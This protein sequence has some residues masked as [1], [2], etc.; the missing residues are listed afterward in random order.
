MDSGQPAEAA[1]I[2]PQC[3]PGT[4]IV[5]RNA[6]VS[7]NLAFDSTNV[8]WGSDDTIMTVPKCGGTPRMVSTGTGTVGG[9]AVEGSNVYWTTLAN[10]PANTL[11]SAPLLGG[12]PT[13][14]AVF[15]GGS[16]PGPLFVESG[17][18]YVINGG[19]GAFTS[20]P[21]A[22]GTPRT[23][24][25]KPGPVSGM[26]ANATGLYWTDS[27]SIFEVSLAGGTPTTLVMTP[28]IPCENDDEQF[29][30]AGPTVDATS[31]YYRTALNPSPPRCLA[32]FQGALMKQRL[33][34][35]AP[36]RLASTPVLYGSP[37]AVG[38]THVYWVEATE[39]YGAY[40]IMA[41]EV[42][43]GSPVT[44]ASV[45]VEPNTLAV[46]G[47]NLYWPGSDGTLMRHTP[48]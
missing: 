28:G 4:A 25:S 26:A 7:T 43:G 39:T 5:A 13:T 6:D 37:L 27:Q 16:R 10:N 42:E 2:E 38:V 18:A 31:L 22:G 23:L 8:Y 46:D 36:I 1:V 32:P 9:V 33:D 12:A 41:V 21:L 35:G 17:N 11:V 29:V 19:T 24:L 40:A 47:E 30:Q 44:V 45:A 48:E 14:L 15:E 20:V 34:G 3:P